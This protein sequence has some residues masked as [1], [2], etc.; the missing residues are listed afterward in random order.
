MRCL[1]TDVMFPNKFSVWRNNEILSFI[2]EFETDILIFKVDS[3]AGNN[4]DFDWEFHNQNGILDDYNILIFNP[5][6]NHLNK[7]NKKIDGTKFN[8]KL[9]A[10]YLITKKEEIDFENYD[11]VYHI[12]LMCYTQF[13]KILNFNKERQFIHLYPGGGLSYLDNI[14]LV[15]PLTNVIS[16][17][18]RTTKKLIEIGHK[19]FINVYMGPLMKKNETFIEKEEKKD[20]ESVSI[21]FSSLGK[22]DDKGND[23]FEKL[24]K[25]YINFPE[26]KIKFH[27]VG[28]F[29]SQENVTIH[30]P[31]DYLSLGKF[32]QENIDIYINSETGKFYNGWPLGLESV[33]SGSVLI[34]TDPNNDHDHYFKQNSGIFIFKDFRQ[35]IEIIEFLYENKKTL[36]LYSKISQKNFSKYL[37]YENQQ[38]KIFEY[39][40]NKLII[41]NVLH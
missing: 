7:L 17:H 38:K 4:F 1:L 13:N 29:K 34:T 20:D 22:S 24:I 10:S 3:F 37:T 15:D 19:N 30:P 2:E 21:C 12:F 40:K 28:N 35:L 41:S 16:T 33:I 31:M 25:H 6:Y 8:N 23:T 9:S 27:T 39:I 36:H 32:Y 11:F 26:K 14:S 18:H 5:K